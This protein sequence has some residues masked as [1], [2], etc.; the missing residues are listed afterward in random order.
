MTSAK[1]FTL[2]ELIVVIILISILS[3]VGIGLFSSSDQYSARLASDR[4]LAGLRLAQRLSLQKQN[5][6]NLVVMTVTSGSDSWGFSIDQAGINLSDFELNILLSHIDLQIIPEEFLKQL[7]NDPYWKE[8]IPQLKSVLSDFEIEKEQ[9]DIRISTSSFSAACS[10]LPVMS[11][12]NTFNF[13]GYGDLVSATR[14]QEST[15]TRLCFIG[16]QTMDLCISPS[17]YTYEGLCAG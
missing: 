13:N 1:G 14:V 6:S 3:A 5:A 10:T 11:F 15:N 7:R 4:W 8:R 9:L 17:G 2:I 16:A 12:P